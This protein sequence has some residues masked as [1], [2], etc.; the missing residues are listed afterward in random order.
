MNSKQNPF[1]TAHEITRDLIAVYRTP[2]PMLA[3]LIG[4]FE[5]QVYP[6]W[7]I[8]EIWRISAVGMTA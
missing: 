7:T 3:H 2:P 1:E 8:R 6:L 5:P 4:G